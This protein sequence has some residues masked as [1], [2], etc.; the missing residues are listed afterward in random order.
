[1]NPSQPNLTTDA[2]LDLDP[3][4]P[5][6]TLDD[7]ALA[8]P[9]A[10]ALIEGGLHVIEI[11]LRTEAALKAIERIAREVPEIHVGAGSICS[12][13]QIAAAIAAGASFLVSPGSSPRLLDALIDA[14]LPFLAGC[15][16]P[17]DALMLLERGVTAAKLFPAEAIGGVALAHALAGPFPHLRLCATGGIDPAKAAQWL[18]LPNVA[19]VG[20]SWLTHPPLPRDGDWSEVVAH[21]RA[22]CSLRDA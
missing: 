15:A 22:A 9:L 1:M 4:I 16:T 17:S 20:G 13:E 6:V 11:T 18:R 8:A 5:I 10:S 2:L 7:A 14:P 12:R 21:A 3:V 19:C